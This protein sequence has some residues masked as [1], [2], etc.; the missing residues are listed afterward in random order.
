MIFLLFLFSPTNAPW[1]G[2]VVSADYATY[3]KGDSDNSRV[4]MTAMA[5]RS[6]SAVEKLAQV[7]RL[8]PQT[9]KGQME[10]IFGISPD[11]CDH[12]SPRYIGTYDSKIA[13]NDVTATQ[14]GTN[15]AQSNV[16]GQV[17]GK[18]LSI[19]S[20]GNFTYSATEHGMIVG[21][22]SS[23]I[24]T[25]YCDDFLDIFNTK[26][27]KSDFFN[28]VY[29]QLG[30][31]PLLNEQTGV[32]GSPLNVLGWQAR[33]IEYK[34]SRSRVHGEFSR[35]T[36]S[37]TAG[38]LNNWCCPYTPI[39]TVFSPAFYKV[40]PFSASNIFLSQYNGLPTSDHLWEHYSFNVTKV[41]DMSVYGLPILN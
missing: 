33:Y 16:L 22:H 2:T 4:Q 36:G 39:G 21:V 27:S 38:S 12:C 1:L 7:A 37:N 35:S 34:T 10:A 3:L 9:Y 31:Q 19:D 6:L 26:L 41:S 17:G 8:S 14:N 28:P 15:G 11:K 32:N 29:D 30:M 24:D 40:N 25:V 20:Q 23:E 13:I 5:I 18:G